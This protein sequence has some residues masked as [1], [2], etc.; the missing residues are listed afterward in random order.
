MTAHLLARGGACDRVA[1][2]V[3]ACNGSRRTV[4]Q[5]G[6][7]GS[8]AVQNAHPSRRPSAGSRMDSTGQAPT[9]RAR[10]AG[11]R[12]GRGGGQAVGHHAPLAQQRAEGGPEGATLGA[13]ALVSK[14][15]A[16]GRVGA[17]HAVGAGGV[18]RPAWGRWVAGG[19]AGVGQQWAA[20]RVLL[21]YK[22]GNIC[23]LMPAPGP[24]PPAAAHLA[25]TSGSSC[26]PASCPSGNLGRRPGQRACTWGHWCRPVVRCRNCHSTASTCTGAGNTK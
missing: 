2:Q 10:Q 14:L 23:T 9:W 24:T 6:S 19:L 11:V 13:R 5:A 1:S 20:A 17:P 15:L 18:A 7:C 21:A 25:R 4:R 26:N 3:V 8:A 12:G 16:G 22:V